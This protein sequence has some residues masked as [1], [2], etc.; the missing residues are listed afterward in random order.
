MSELSQQM[1]K[2]RSVDDVI[3]TEEI[4]RRPSRPPDY[5]AENRALVALAQKIT[6][7]PQGVLQRVAELAMELCHADSA[8]IS[9]LE[10]GGNHG[11]FRWHAAAGAFAANLGGTMPREA[12][13]CGIVISRNS[14]LLF[15][16]AERFF[17]ALRDVKPRIYENLLAPWAVNGQVV[18][19]LWAIG[20]R[21]T[22]HFDAE[23]ARLLQSLAGFASAAYS[24]LERTRV[25]KELRSE[26]AAALNLMEDAVAARQEAERANVA[27]RESEERMRH[28]LSIET[29]GVL[30]FKLDGRIID[31]NA[32]FQRMSGY[33]GAELRA[34]AHW[35]HLTAPEFMERTTRATEALALRGETPPYEKQLIHKEGALWWGLF[36]PTRLTGHGLDS[37]CVEFII[38]IT[39]AKATEAALRASEEQ[40]RRAIEE[41]PVP[42]IMHAEDGQVLQISKTWT[43]L[44]GYTPE[45]IPTFD[46]WLN[47]AYGSGADQVRE[48]V[49]RLFGGDTR[50]LD[51][52]IEVT[53][54]SG[55]NRLWLFSASAPGTLRDGRRFIVGMALDITERKRV[56]EA[57]ARSEERLRLIVENARDF[58]I[59]SIDLERRVTSW[60]S[61]AERMLG[62]TEREIMGELADIIFTPEDRALHACEQEAETALRDGRASDERWHVHKNGSCFWGSGVMTTMHDSHGNVVGFV[63]IFR[64]Q[65]KERA[66]QQALEEALAENARAREEIEA[67]AQAKDHFLAML[68]HELRTPLTPVMMSAGALMR[69]TDLTAQTRDALE[70]IIR[71]IEIESRFVDD[72]LDITRISRGKLDLVREPMDIHEMIAR[73]VEVCAPDMQA[74]NQRFSLALHAAEHRTRGDSTRLQQAIWNLLKN[75]SKF[76]PE[77]G[78]VSL[79]SFNEPGRI[80]IEISDNGVGIDAA[81]LPRI[82]DPFEQANKSVSRQFGGLGLGL[83]I[84][85]AIV[86]AHD[87]VLRATSEGI[88]KG[89][90][91]TI[92]LPL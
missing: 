11:I 7:D 58:A 79:R 66:A 76:T 81:A 12:S 22:H 70:M 77:G 4:T 1:Q 73:T 65:T 46:A 15:N 48:H 42:V 6:T 84:T 40:F 85:K 35:K 78:K 21:P 91:F 60:N 20:H 50:L 5:A 34:M 19:T 51:A 88:G 71:N 57:L 52:E 63:K 82:F 28:A 90:M 39:G 31:A 3:I 62:Y 45:D 44:T 92:E 67:A 30:F 43:E 41:A 53:T 69:R 47:R 56:E 8:G 32:A 75:A 55:G 74:K 17:A 37:E 38:D 14:V 33:S 49:R 68:S 13:P 59:F 2:V 24:L 83:A 87:G 26:R 80:A 86:E 10:P 18:G 89:S 54:R 72:L 25:A 36:A 23:D 64:D 29:V 61:G 9:I 16:E 27:L